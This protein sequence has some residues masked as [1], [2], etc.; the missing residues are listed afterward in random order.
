MNGTLS[1]LVVPV[2]PA[3]VFAAE[4]MSEGEMRPT[5]AVFTQLQ[6]GNIFVDTV[7]VFPYPINVF[8]KNSLM[9]GRDNVTV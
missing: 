3:S 2:C 1:R 9:W 7:G 4:A 5:E 6:Q 8:S